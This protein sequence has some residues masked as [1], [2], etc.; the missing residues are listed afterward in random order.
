MALKLRVKLGGVN[1]LSDARYAAGMGVEAIGFGIDKEQQGFLD[2][3]AMHAI[4]DWIAGIEIVGETDSNLPENLEEYKIDMLEVK[5]TNLLGNDKKYLLRLTADNDNIDQLPHLFKTNVDLV[6]YFMVDIE[7]SDLAELGQDLKLL[8]EIYPIF[9][10]TSFDA[11]NLHYVLEVIQPQGIELK[12]GMEEKPGL[13]SY[14][15]IADILE[16]LEED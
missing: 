11:Y 12:G 14:D 10:A 9:I 8:A 6:E 15:G 2:P 5:D 1:N 7:A 3:E 13:S 4:S 16:L